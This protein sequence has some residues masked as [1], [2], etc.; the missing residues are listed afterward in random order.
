MTVRGRPG[1][2]RQPGR[3]R[4][5]EDLLQDAG[6][7]EDLRQRIERMRE[8]GEI[9]APGA[10]PKTR[11]DLNAGIGLAYFWVTQCFVAIA[12]AFVEP[13]TEE[14]I[15]ELSREQAVALLGRCDR[16]R[17]DA[18]AALTD[19][20][21]KGGKDLPISLG[22]RLEADDG[23]SPPEHL[24][25]LLR[26]ADRLD[27]EVQTDVRSYCDALGG[28]APAGAR[29]AARQLEGE[30]ARAQANLDTARQALFPLLKGERLD[31]ETRR[32]AE[33]YL[34]SALDR[35]VWLGQVVAVPTLRERAR[36][37]SP[38]RK[39]DRAGAALAVKK[40]R[41]PPVHPETEPRIWDN[42]RV[43]RFLLRFA[44]SALF[45]S[46]L[47]AFLIAVAFP[48]LFPGPTLGL[49]GVNAVAVDPRGALYLADLGNNRV[50]KVSRDHHLLARWGR[51]G[52]APGQFDHPA[53]IAL[54]RQ[55]NV[56]VLD[57]GNNRIQKLSPSGRP[58]AVFGRRGHGPGQFSDPEGFALDPRGN[59]YVADTSND[60]IQEL[61]PR[62]KV[63]KVWGTPGNPLPRPALQ[64][65]V[66]L[67]LDAQGNLHVADQGTGLIVEISPHGHVEDT[68]PFNG[69]DS[70]PNGIAV[71]AHGYLYVT[72]DDL[73]V[74]KYAGNDEDFERF[75]DKQFFSFGLFTDP[76]Q[77]AL[78]ARGDVY[79]ADASDNRIVE[80]AP[81]GESLD[82]WR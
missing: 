21:F 16:L 71:D 56:Y 45:W 64:R 20:D 68:F 22:P 54:D 17:R 51:R 2:R 57:T 13:E 41:R 66:A 55:G 3:T 58:L 33:S 19:P 78:D 49:K 69:G 79:V 76:R 72:G 32:D 35:Y 34:W 75:S 52:T 62:G 50:V 36:A 28:D 46:P 43:R 60:R 27:V 77:L 4:D 26:A 24:K 11:A 18:E 9:L 47:L 6:Y 39:R 48:A 59:I 61:S 73:D 7:V 25:A 23:P 40:P 10:S 37:P 12:R 30:L 80:L 31:E 70:Y 82:T 63:L 8:A 5:V 81:T 42:P 29:A 74:E 53:D 65:P 15:A 14:R 38:A 67:A 44:I 1:A